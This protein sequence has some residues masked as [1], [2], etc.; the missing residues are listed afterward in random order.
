M[1]FTAVPSTAAVM[2]CSVAFCVGEAAMLMAAKRLYII[3]DN[4]VVL[5]VLGR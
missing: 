2:G 1:S 4:Y 3:S 5:T